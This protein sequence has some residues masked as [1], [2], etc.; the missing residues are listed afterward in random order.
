MSSRVATRL[1]VGFFLLFAVM[2]VW[3]AFTLFNRVEP[4]ILGLP[5][6]MAWVAIWLVA[7]IGILYLVDRARRRDQ[8]D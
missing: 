2:V 4:L 6:N 5:F 3:P 8:E 1:A 7:S